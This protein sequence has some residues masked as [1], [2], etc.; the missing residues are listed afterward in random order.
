MK[1]ILVPIDF[2]DVTTKIIEQTIKLASALNAK[3]HLIHV[4]A[5]SS[6]TIRLQSEN[7]TA[8]AGWNGGSLF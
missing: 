1:T 7:N 8:H 5:P 4:T 6:S 2:S 3:V